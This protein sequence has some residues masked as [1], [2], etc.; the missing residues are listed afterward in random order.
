ML[1]VAL[2]DLMARKRRLVTTSI[3]V[4]LGIA[5]LTGTQ[6]LSAT[7]NDSIRSLVADVY[8]GVDAVVR[9]PKT[10]STPFGQPLRTPVE[11]TV[12]DEVQGVPGVDRAQGFVEAAGNELIDSKGKVFGGGVGPPTITYNWVED[13]I[14]GTGGVREGRGPTADDEIAIDGTSADTLGLKPGDPVKVATL[15]GGVK[16]YTLVGVVGLGADGEGKTGAK[17]IFFTTAEAQ[18]ITGQPGQYNFVAV[19]AEPGI[20]QR[21]IARTLAD[22]L[23]Q[24]Q[25]ITGRQFVE[26]NQE[27]I[28]KFVDILST[29][30]SVFGYVAL[31]VAIFIIYNTFSILVQQRT[32]ETALLRAVGARRRQVLGAS[33][34]EAVV[35]GVIASVLGLVL[36]VII[37]MLLVN[38]LQNLFTMAGS[39]A[40]PGVGNVVFALVVGVGITV[41]SALAPAWRST[42][43]PPIAALGEVSIDRSNLSR[44]RMVVGVLMVLV[45]GALIGLGLADTGPSPVA[46]VGVGAVMVLVSFALVIGPTM[47]SP[48]SRLLARVMGPV[49]GVSARL[50][51]ENAARNPKRT[52]STAA[53]LTIGVT[54]V[55]L[56]AV[57]ASSIKASTDK[58]IDQSV[59]AD[60]VVA[61]VSLTSF[62]AIPP[63]LTEKISALDDV[64]V[65]SPL[66]FGFMRL[67]DA[68]AV[69][70]AATATTVPPGTFGVPDDAPPGEDTAVLGMDPRT[71]FDV[72]DAGTTDGSPSDLGPGTVAVEKHYAETRG[73]RLGDTIPVYFGATG[74]QELKVAMLFEQGLGQTPIWLPMDTFAANQLPL[75][76][77]DYQI[78]VK[79]ADGA[80]MSE[81]RDQLDALVADLP[82]VAVQDLQ[83]YV[84]AQTGPINTF[85]YIVYGLL[86]LAIIIALVGITNTLAL[87]ILERTREL[88]LLRAIGMSRRQLRRTVRYEAAIIAVFGA[89]MGLVLGVVFSAALTVA[90]AADNPGL[91]TYHLPVVQLVAITV[92]AAV[93]GVVAA[94]LPARRAARLDVLAAIASN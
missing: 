35:V 76:N 94:W 81:L 48:F 6:L 87:S 46:M 88:G 89:L 64:A 8:Q 16:T 36:G 38:A 45:G 4:V 62:G 44:S 57:I 86:A 80:S 22:A 29:F 27:S 11:A 42:R 23:P 60:Y 52:A 31:F 15:T 55:T 30:V 61:T 2:K 39:P 83:Q 7:L 58:M 37:A 93:A 3:A 1:R 56:I 32:R 71:W 73:W 75:F 21:E 33:L 84:E 68:K 14:M 26:E 53:A 25:V 12:L 51:G 18:A 69:A 47:A 79:G 40:L 59:T 20:G 85:L 78:Y 41:V 67:L 91:V 9:S 19:R 28:S 50:A 34:L 49:G 70:N 5:F 54:L 13:S 17:P 74:R 10:T 43:V 92:I 66:R 24:E 72:V 82:T 65:A 63:D 77:S 90:V